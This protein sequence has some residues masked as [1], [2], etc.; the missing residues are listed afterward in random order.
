MAA[1]RINQSNSPK[2]NRVLGQTVVTP[3]ASLVRVEIYAVT[4]GGG[5]N[6]RYCPQ[7]QRDPYGKETFYCLLEGGT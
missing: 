7:R 3:V 6:G 5:A 2:V 4:D 1:N